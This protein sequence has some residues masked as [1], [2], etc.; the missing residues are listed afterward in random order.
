MSQASVIDLRAPH[1]LRDRHRI[2]VVDIENLV[3]GCC[4]PRESV[5]LA[6]DAFDAAAHTSDADLVFVAAAPRLAF[7]CGCLRPAAKHYCARGVDGAELRLMAEV[8][9]DF[10]VQRASELVIG[11]GDHLFLDYALDVRRAGVPVRIVARR[12]S[13]H[14]RYWTFGF[15]ITVLDPLPAAPEPGR[16]VAVAA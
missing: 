5:A 13:I 14:H 12:R 2:A 7:D 1:E 10:V 3:G 6:L 11:S 9:V 8:P 16:G 4:C 15:D